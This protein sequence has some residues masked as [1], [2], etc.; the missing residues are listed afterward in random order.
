MVHATPREH[1]AVA[2]TLRPVDDG[3]ARG[4]GCVT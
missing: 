2:L 4:N 1:A 3:V